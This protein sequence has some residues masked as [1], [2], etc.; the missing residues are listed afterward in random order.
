MS[1]IERPKIDLV[2][3]E[4]ARAIY[5]QGTAFGDEKVGECGYPTCGARIAR[6]ENF[7]VTAAG[8]IMHRACWEKVT[9]RRIFTNPD[10]TL[11]QKYR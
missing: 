6:W 8:A 2:I 1:V 3:A 10:G 4:K 5:K 9:P 11:K 7:I